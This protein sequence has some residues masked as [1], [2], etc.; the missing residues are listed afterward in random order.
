MIK[1]TAAAVLLAGVAGFGMVPAVAAQSACT[2][3]GG[4]VDASAQCH[5]DRADAGFRFHASFPVGYPDQQ[6]VASY[7]TGERDRMADYAAT[8]PPIGRESG[9]ELTI[10]GKPYQSA[11]TESVVFAAQNDSGAANDG[12]PATSYTAFTYDLGRGSPI[13]FASLFKPGTTPADVHAAAPNLPAPD[14][15]GV[16]GYRNF[17]LTDDAMVIF[18]DQDFLHVGPRSVSVPRS[19]LAALL[20]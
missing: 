10:T 8:F 9:Y 1:W 11:G 12:R 6:A 7:L 13:T 14:D 17:A 15:F 3:L 19:E 2:D 16:H 18:I 5:I 4:T 20:A